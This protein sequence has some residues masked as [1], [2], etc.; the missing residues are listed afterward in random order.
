MSSPTDPWGAAAPPPPPSP[1]A[2]LEPPDAAHRR[3]RS[4][5]W[6]VPTVGVVA[7]GVG[8]AWLAKGRS[9]SEV[10]CVPNEPATATVDRFSVEPM[11]SGVP[12]VEP[13]EVPYDVQV[14]GTV[15]NDSDVELSVSVAVPMV[16]YPDQIAYSQRRIV[17]EPQASAEYTATGGLMQGS[18]VPLTPDETAVRVDWVQSGDLVPTCDPP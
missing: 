7:V 3:R 12:G 18:S 16:S 9:E 13:I 2:P 15:T 10:R 14:H 17:L 4:R 5:R 11:V 8:A 1:S 6:I